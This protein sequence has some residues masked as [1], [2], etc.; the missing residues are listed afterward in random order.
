MSSPRRPL[1]PALVSA[2]T[3]E[4]QARWI[5]WRPRR[6]VT[7]GYPIGSGRIESACKQVVTTRC[8]G[9]GMRWEHPQAQA[10]LWARCAWLNGEWD[11][12]IE[13]ACRAA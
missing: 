9:P 4:V 1:D 3:R 13:Q 5:G 10:V 2:V 6:L 11:R 7:R 12:A 8:K